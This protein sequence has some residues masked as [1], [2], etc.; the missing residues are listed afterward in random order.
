[1]Y[2]GQGTDKGG[3]KIVKVVAAQTYFIQLFG[4][5]LGKFAKACCRCDE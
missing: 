5:K 4:R 2:P 3:G 1:M